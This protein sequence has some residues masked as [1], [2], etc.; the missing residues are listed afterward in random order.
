M[1]SPHAAGVAALIASVRR[2]RRRRGRASWQHRRTRSLAR[3]TRRLTTS[4]RP[5]TTVR[6]RP[7]RAARPEQLVRLGGGGRAG[8]CPVAGNGPGR[9][10]HH[11]C[12]P[13]P[14]PARPG[15]RVT[16]RRG[17]HPHDPV[18]GSHADEARTRMTRY[19][20]HMPTRPAPHRFAT[21]RFGSLVGSS[22]GT[23]T[24][25]SA[26]V[27]VRAIRGG[28]ARRTGPGAAWCRPPAAGVVV[29][30]GTHVLLA[31]RFVLIIEGSSRH[32]LGRSF[33]ITR[34]YLRR[35]NGFVACRG[36]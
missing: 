11:R 10:G 27:S 20:G 17:P 2:Q 19:E 18:R 15:T 36:C 35:A 31:N 24:S 28:S 12:A 1:A 9:T 4:S 33:M 5:S 26:M 14:A 13:R 32:V 25:V 3:P 8:R 22:G 29:R 6:R 23:L 30:H 7:A 34:A 21:S 16:C